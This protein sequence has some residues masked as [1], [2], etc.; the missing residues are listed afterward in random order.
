MTND[1][2]VKPGAS[3]MT[4]AE[5]RRQLLDVALLLV[6]EAGP[7]RLTL[8]R[9]AERAGVSKPVAYDHFGTR[10]GLL[11]ELYKTIDLQQAE[12]LRAALSDQSLSFGETVQRLAD[13]YIHCS[14]DTSGEWHIVGAALSG[15]V[16]MERVRQEL[17]GEY[18]QLFAALLEPFGNIDKRELQRR[19]VGLIGAGEALSAMMVRGDCSEDEAGRSFAALIRNGLS[20]PNDLG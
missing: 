16:E 6:R 9:L 19:C 10:S 13:A 5:R 15:N 11:I 8:G 20:A 12:A 18:V 4:K 2:S 14:A 3:R 7:D 17:V 1:M